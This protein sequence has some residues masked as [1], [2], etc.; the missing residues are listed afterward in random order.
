M[1]NSSSLSSMTNESLEPCPD[2]LSD[3]ILYDPVV[4]ISFIVLGIINVIVICGNSLVVTAVLITSKLK[5]ITN[6]F[7]V[8][9]AVA[10]LLV[11]IT[12]LPF[13]MTFEV[14]DVWVFGSSWC[15]IWLAVDVWLSTSSILNLCAISFD[16]YIAVTRPVKYPSL[17]TPRRAHIL[18]ASVWVMSFV[19]CF[20]P[21]VGWND[22]SN[23]SGVEDHENK[24]NP[25]SLNNTQQRTSF[26]VF[27][28]NITATINDIFDGY[29]VTIDDDTQ[30]ENS[31]MK[32]TVAK[33]SLVND[34][35]Y[36]IYSA[37]G[38]F[39]LP[40]VIMLFFYWRIYKA[41][42]STTK[43]INQGYITTKSGSTKG[44]KRM[45]EQR[46]T[47]RIHRGRS[48]YNPT[49]KD[50]D[51]EGHKRNIQQNSG[52]EMRTSPAHNVEIS[53]N[54]AEATP[55][56]QLL[57]SST[58]RDRPQGR[59][60]SLKNDRDNENKSERPR[61]YSQLSSKSSSSSDGKDMSDS[62]KWGGMMSSKRSLKFQARRFRTETKAAKTVGIILG[63]FF[64]C[65]APFF[66]I[67]LIGG[68]NERIIP[69]WLFSVFFWLGYC[70]SGINPC[71]YALFS[72]DFRNAF[73]RILCRCSLSDEP[74]KFRVEGAL[75]SM[76]KSM[77]L[78][79]NSV[80]ED[81]DSTEKQNVS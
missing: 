60:V 48:Y 13:S 54:G 22:S 7:I 76:L 41:A 15:Q 66:T 45:D 73:K 9:L 20:P 39:Y 72:K 2:P 53:I 42:I 71:I 78:N 50:D 24:T 61:L 5:T 58:K 8:S 81:S 34:K 33:C 57:R 47:L 75:S 10:D 17:M 29:N 16:R 65:W 69:S 56:T 64:V 52:K 70:N 31:G 74:P 25:L 32:C 12:I 26:S 43:A 3:E 19:I 21:L 55:C 18:I 44:K 80:G 1:Y 28:S 4:I 77:H 62:L 27:V 68:F 38:S 37:L 49:N 67:Y 35:G 14:L 36:R 46:L 51:S 23:Q 40:M 59:S 79:M 11:G 63:A 6:Y 30:F